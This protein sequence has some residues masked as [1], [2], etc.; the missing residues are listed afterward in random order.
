MKYKKPAPYSLL[1]NP[2]SPNYIELHCH[3][4]FSLLDGAAHPEDLVVRAA[5]LGMTALALTDH[6]AVYGAVRFAQAAQAHHIRPIFGAEMTL[7]NGHHLTLLVEHKI[8][9]RNLCR[10]I[11]LARHNA[12]KGQAALP[13]EAL[14]G[15]TEGLIALSGCRQGEL[16]TTLRQKQWAVAGDIARRYRDLFGSDN[17]WIELQDHLQPDDGAL[18]DAQV[19]LARHLR[20]GYLTTNNVHYS[21]RAGQY[22]RNVLRCIRQRISLAQLDSLGPL[23][24]ELYLKTGRHL[25]PLFANYPDALANT[26][27][28]A[29]RCRFE[30]HY[31]LQALPH[32]PTPPGL[33]A[34]MYLY[35]LCQKAVRQR[36]VEP[37]EQVWTQLTH[38]LTVIEQ[39][40]L[41]NYF[42]IVWDIVRFARTQGIRCQ[43]RGSAANSLVAYLLHISPVDPL[44]HDL[45]FERFLSAEREVVP[46]IDLDFQADRREEV[47]QYVYQ[48]YGLEHAAMACTL[49]TYRKRS[50]WRDV[51]QALGLPATLLAQGP[52]VLADKQTGSCANRSWTSRDTWASTMAA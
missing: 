26:L 28:I 5:E 18:V 8:G 37:A 11:N 21:T 35:Q 47:I 33:D 19:A 15:R 38:E 40:G 27:K 1:H 4:N 10:L 51:G 49:V 14:A 22:L 16:A 43:G 25:R 42:L 3:S 2:Y 41:T 48:R 29:G 13:P 9:W 39:A 31:G 24:S 32:F 20:L 12:P 17:F 7:V 44:A 23:N 30:L 36:Y 45:I 52:D 46:D 50:A 6:D 34:E